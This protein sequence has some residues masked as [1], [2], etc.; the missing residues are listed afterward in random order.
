[1]RHFGL[2]AV[3][4][5][6]VTATTLAACDGDN[7]PG[8]S[9][10]ATPGTGDAAADGGTP[11]P[12]PYPLPTLTPFPSNLAQQVEGIKELVAR[13]R[14]LPAPTLDREGILSA[15]SVEQ[16]YLEALNSMA[17]EDALEAKAG[18]RV[19]QM[20]GLVPDGYSLED[21]SS[22][23]SGNIAGFYSI[24]EDAFVVVVGQT[25]DKLSLSQELTIAHELTHAM[26]DDAFDLDEFHQRYKDHAQ[27]SAGYT[28]YEEMTSCV[29]EGDATFT[30]LKYAEALLGPDWR[31]RI[32]AESDGDQQRPRAELPPFLEDELSFDYSHCYKFIESVFEKGGWKAVNDLYQN[33]P[34]TQEQVLDFDKFLDGQLASRAAPPGLEDKLPGWQEG[35]GSG[36]FGEYDVGAYVR[37]LSSDDNFLGSLY[38]YF[39]GIGWGA[40]WLRSYSD[41][42]DSDRALVQISL[43]FE[44]DDDCNSFLK[45]FAPIAAGFGAPIDVPDIVNVFRDN[46]PSP[47]SAGDTVSW[48]NGPTAGPV[49]FITVSSTQPGVD[50]FVATDADTLSMV[51]PP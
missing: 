12:T 10:T 40:G 26:Q 11:S 44:S 21:M 14:G 24:Q 51:T 18:N 27:D 20:L 2:L 48:S 4:L 13:V 29:D 1:M 6:V 5:V 28:S 35:P 30:E 50:I 47:I 8:P 23:Y 16:H 32:R 7:N 46:G 42:S 45:V 38:G 36:Q 17:E 15:A 22:D 19:L 39:G 43:S 3:P 34:A 25:P 37:A 31:D 9:V 49:G 41:P 33:P